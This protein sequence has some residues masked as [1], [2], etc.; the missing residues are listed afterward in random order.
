MKTNQEVNELKDRIREL[1]ATIA[2][3]KARGTQLTDMFNRI[4]MIADEL[5]DAI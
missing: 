1:E 3:Y 5:E 4:T 2:H